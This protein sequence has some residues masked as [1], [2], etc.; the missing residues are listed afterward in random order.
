MKQ[1][2]SLAVIG[3]CD[4]GKTVQ[5]LVDAGIRMLHYDIMDGHYVPNLCLPLDGVKELK[6]RYPEVELDVH[7]MTEHPENYFETLRQSGADSI[8]FHLDATRFSYRLLQ[9]LHAM[10]IKAGIV[11]NPSQSIYLLRPLLGHFDYVLYMTVEPGFGGQQ[12]LPETAERLQQLLDLRNSSR[13]GFEIYVD[14]GVTR[15]LYTMYCR[16]GVDVAVTGLYT[17]IRQPEGV[18]GALAALKEIEA[19]NRPG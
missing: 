11:I 13:S 6:K 7:L 19:C 14:A 4:F 16:M 15:E 2:P 5:E 9:T 8:S 12:S 17:I 1:A 10:G 18:R 3:M